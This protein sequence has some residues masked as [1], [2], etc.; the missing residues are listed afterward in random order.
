MKPILLVKMILLV[1]VGLKLQNAGEI[2]E[3]LDTQYKMYVRNGDGLGEMNIIVRAEVPTP[4]I[5]LTDGKV[6]LLGNLEITHADVSGSQRVLI[7]NPDTDGLIRFSINNLSRLDATNTG[8]DVYGDL[9]YTGSIIPSSDKRLK[10]D[11][12][13]VNS[14]KAVELLKFIKPKTYPF[15]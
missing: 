4:E 15:Y 1:M 2:R 8:V 10:K 12:K 9:S 3:V 13:E 5:Q 14:K 11:I 7:N 6:N